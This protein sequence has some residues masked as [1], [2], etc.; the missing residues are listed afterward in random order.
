MRVMSGEDSLYTIMN[1]MSRIIEESVECKIDK[2]SLIENKIN[3]EFYEQLLIQPLVFYVPIDTLVTNNDYTDFGLFSNDIFYIEQIYTLLACES[4][5]NKKQQKLIVKWII[6]EADR[7]IQKI[8]PLQTVV[9]LDSLIEIKDEQKNTVGRI[10]YPRL[11]EMFFHI[12]KEDGLKR[13]LKI[14]RKYFYSAIFNIVSSNRKL[15]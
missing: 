9:M 12:Y 6:C 11:E 7:T 14:P 10:D 15:R 1:A 3:D 8:R 4:L 5:N 13:F 2:K